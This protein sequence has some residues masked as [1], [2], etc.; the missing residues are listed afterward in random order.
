MNIVSEFRH[1][2]SR[3]HHGFIRD[4]TDKVEQAFSAAHAYGLEIL[5]LLSVIERFLRLYPTAPHPNSPLTPSWGNTPLCA[6]GYAGHKTNMK[7]QKVVH[8]REMLLRIEIGG[9]RQDPPVALVSVYVPY[10]NPSA[11]YCFGVKF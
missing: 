2:R 4:S 3:R 8:A 5:G 1:F 9:V 10:G 6:L 11:K 7:R